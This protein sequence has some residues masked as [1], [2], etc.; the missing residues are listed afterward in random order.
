MED[1]T[2]LFVDDEKNILQSLERYLIKEPYNKIFAQSADQALEIFAKEPVHV[3]VTDMKM[4]EKD[5]LTMLR[6]VKTDYPDTVRIVLSGFT[7]VAQ[8]IPSIN[9]GEIFRY[10]IKPLEPSEFKKTL[11]DAIE[12]YLMRRDKEELIITLTQKNL[13][14]RLT[15]K[16][17]LYLAV[18]DGLTDLYNIRHL[19]FDLEKRID[20]GENPLSIIFMD[21]D[22][23]KHLVDSHG[24][25]NGSKA[26]KEVATTINKVLFDPCYGVAYGGDEF[27]VA[28]PGFDK[29]LALKKTEELRNLMDQT[30]YLSDTGL[31]LHLSASYGVATFPDDA[32]D[33]TELLSQ[34]DTKLFKVKKSRKGKTA[35]R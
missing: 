11:N 6:Q 14:L 34:A 31:D 25:L 5:G 1:I 8:I 12:H 3:V 26:L 4:P 33:L 29:A 9:T 15:R 10:V 7:E 30:R 19:Y 20:S 13:E 21:M 27:V 32:K 23:F 35:T 22:N 18:H 17:L 2:I 28:L 16:K 24:H